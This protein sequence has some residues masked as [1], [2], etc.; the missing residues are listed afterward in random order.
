[1]FT[2]AT[3]N[4][5]SIRA[6]EERVLAWL[7]KAQP[8]VVCLQE[9]KVT[10]DDFPYDSLRGAGYHCAVFG[11]PTYNGVAILSRSEPSNV[12]L[13]FDDGTDDQDARAVTA[14]IGDFSVSSLYIP[15][16]RTV[17]SDKWEYKLDWLARLDRFVTNR[18]DLSAKVLL[19]GDFNIA[20]DDRDVAKPDRWKDSVLCHP[21]G[22]KALSKLTDRGLVDTTRLYHEGPGPYSWW[23]YRML[24]F[25]KG[26]GLRIDHIFA[27][28]P[29]AELCVDASIHRDERKGEKPSDHVPVLAVFEP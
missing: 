4:V 1:M 12:M 28:E 6:R 8:D 23:D 25:P 17:G 20:P 3:W 15:N 5:N 9:L 27:S 16:G 2:V 11:Q 10:E 7:D 26:D 19:C 18:L 22:R 21:Q 13:G 24:A 14:S 29:A